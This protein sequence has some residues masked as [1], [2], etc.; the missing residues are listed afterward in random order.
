MLSLHCIV[1]IHMTIRCTSTIM[2]SQDLLN[3]D[4]ILESLTYIK[5]IS[6]NNT[7]ILYCMLLLVVK[8]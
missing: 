8:L 5:Y 4:N 3:S 2:Y 6:I 7:I 1:L